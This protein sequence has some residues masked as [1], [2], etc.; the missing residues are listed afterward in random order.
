VAVIALYSLS[1]RVASTE[2]SRA[3][4]GSETVKGGLRHHAELVAKECYR[5]EKDK[6][7][8]AVAKNVCSFTVSMTA[9]GLKSDRDWP[10][11][12]TLQGDYGGGMF[13]LKPGAA[14]PSP[15]LAR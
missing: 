13:E 1:E 14:P 5:Q 11:K 12:K 15:R 10:C 7:G 4:K 6:F 2:N 3:S 8:N 9:C